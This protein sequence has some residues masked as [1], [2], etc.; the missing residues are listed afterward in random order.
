MKI[1]AGINKE[2]REQSKGENKDKMKIRG[3][4]Q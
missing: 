3:K 4:E 2:M 1:G